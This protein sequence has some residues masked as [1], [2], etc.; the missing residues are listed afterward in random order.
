MAHFI[1]KNLETGSQF[2]HYHGTFH[3]NNFE[4]IYH[5]LMKGKPD[6]KVMTIASVSQASTRKI[7]E[8]NVS[9]ANFIIVTPED[10][11]KSY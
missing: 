3:S 2:I 8:D 1:L 5:Y 7:E 4:G 11:P 9:L 10:G 6:L